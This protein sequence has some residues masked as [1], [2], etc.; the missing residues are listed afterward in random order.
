MV[1][2][3]TRSETGTHHRQLPRRALPFSAL[4]KPTEDAAGDA[5]SLGVRS[6]AGFLSGFF[7]NGPIS[8]QG[9][10]VQYLFTHCVSF[11]FALGEAAESRSDLQSIS[12]HPLPMVA[13]PEHT[14]AEEEAVICF[15]AMTAFPSNLQG[16]DGERFLGASPDTEL[17]NVKCIK[18][19]TGKT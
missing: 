4:P 15:K 5:V 12:P 10:L 16:E 13:M 1:K 2:L 11:C 9:N 19:Y 18:D 8:F 7:S 3:P 17:C 14:K 6:A